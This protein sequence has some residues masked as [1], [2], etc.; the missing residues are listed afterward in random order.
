MRVPTELDVRL[1]D[2]TTLTSANSGDALRAPARPATHPHHPEQ[3]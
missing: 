3:A 1:H 2:R